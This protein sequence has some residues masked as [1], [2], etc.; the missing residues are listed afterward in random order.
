MMLLN[1]FILLLDIFSFEKNGIS[2]IKKY[3]INQYIPS[4][5]LIFNN[6]NIINVRAIS[7]GTKDFTYHPIP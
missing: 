3:T 1:I 7:F 6:P 2:A 5:S 4:G